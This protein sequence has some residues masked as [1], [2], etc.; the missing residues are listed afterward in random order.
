MLRLIGLVLVA[1]LLVGSESMQAASTSRIV[2]VLRHYLDREGR[3]ALSP[4]LLDRDAYQAQLRDHPEQVSGLRFEIQLRLKSKEAAHY[5][6]RIEIRHGKGNQVE[7]FR[8]EVEIQRKRRSQ[9][10]NVP[11]I[12]EDFAQLNEVIAWRVLLLDGE[13]E[14]GTVESFLW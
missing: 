14:L 2:K 13:S 4:S 6:L 11:V 10:V 8:K 3:H 12:D 9:W 5:R 1:G 7:T